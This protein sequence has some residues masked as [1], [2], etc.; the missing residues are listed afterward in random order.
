M[1]LKWFI[2][3]K[4]LDELHMGIYDEHHFYNYTLKTNPILQI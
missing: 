2:E 3:V 4:W 1:A